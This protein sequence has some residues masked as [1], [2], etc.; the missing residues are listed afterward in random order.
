MD[1]DPREG[2]LTGTARRARKWGRRVT[3]EEADA[4]I[5]ENDHL[6]RDLAETDVDR[7][8]GAIRDLDA[9]RARI[10][11]LEAENTRLRAAMQP[12]APIPDT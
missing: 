12:P 2:A 7:R 9:A 3:D 11:E 8:V 4:L 1:E 5:A 6:R 10:A